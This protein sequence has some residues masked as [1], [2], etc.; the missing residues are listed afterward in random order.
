MAT[1]ACFSQKEIEMDITGIIMAGGK[2]S[3]L[4]QDK[5]L[6]QIGDKKLVEIATGLLSEVCTEVMI[7]AG[8]PAYREFGCRVIPD[9]YTGIGPM[10]GL[11][12]ALSAS[13]SQINVV[14]SVDIPFVNK[15]LIAHLISRLQDYQAVVPHTGPGRLEPLCAV[16]HSSVLPVIRKCIENENYKLQHFIEMVKVNKT[17]ISD[18]L[19]FYTPHLFLNINTPGDYSKAIKLI[20]LS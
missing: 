7:S 6:L 15:G 18:D 16:Y 4:G 14:L 2:S 20:D 12:S 3:R 10:G 11:Y 13:R 8:N 5:G 17:V 19:P 9:I 1:V